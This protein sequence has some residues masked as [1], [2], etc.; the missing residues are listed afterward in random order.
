[1]LTVCLFARRK[2]PSSLEAYDYVLRGDVLGLGDPDA[3]AEAGQLYERAIEI[4]PGYGLA[5]SKLAYILSLAWVREQSDDTGTL[6]RAFDLAKRAVVLD[7][8]EPNCHRALGWVHLFRR[9]FDLAERFY[10]RTL[11]LNPNSAE[12]TS[13][14]GALNCFLGNADEALRWYEKA[15][16]L[17]PYFEPA[18]FWRLQGIAHFTANRLPDAIACFGHSPFIPYWARVYLAACHALIGDDTRAAECVAKVLSEAPDFSLNR[19]AAKEPLRRA[20]DTARLI[21]GMRKAGLP[22]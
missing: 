8:D 4:D 6:D 2:R 13:Y 20:T 21:E 3:E 11:E 9:S 7:P 16:Q 5:Y 10:R 19:F 22:E 12:Q 1:M 14:L 17:D 15:R 18:P